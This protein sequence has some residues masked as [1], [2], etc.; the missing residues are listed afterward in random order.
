M[1]NFSSNKGQIAA[2][3]LAGGAGQRVGGQDKGLMPWRGSPLVEHVYRRIKPQVAEVWISCNRNRNVYRQYAPL[4]PVDLR[5][6]YQGPLAG[7]EAAAGS[8]QQ[9]YILVVPCDTP[10]LPANLASCL[11][12]ALLQN[13]DHNVAYAR[14]GDRSHYLCA[15]LRRNCLESLGA[16]LDDGQRA[17]R[18]WYQTL[19]ALAV[20]FP[21]QER[22]FLNLNRTEELK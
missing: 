3:I 2:L 21:A 5:V 6:D 20:D 15:L 19:G 17:V 22:E 18:F 10:A 7:I 8:L 13:P 14:S 11:L 12:Q 4:T 9:E 16:Y 1:D